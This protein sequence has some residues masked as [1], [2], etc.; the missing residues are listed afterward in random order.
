MRLHRVVV[1][2][3]GTCVVGRAVNVLHFDATEQDAPPVAAIRD[4]YQAMSAQL[5]SGVTVRV[6]GSGETIEDSTGDLTGVWNDAAPAVVVGGV[7]P[8]A[9]A[10]VGA[11]VTWNT[12]GIVTGTAGPRRL[13]G[14]TFLVPLANACFDSD[15]T[16]TGPALASINAFGAGMIAAGGFGVWHRPSSAAATDGTSSSVLSYSLRD[17]V[18]V[19]TSRRD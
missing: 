14:R 13:R 17:K 19:L 18:A 7:V 9:A 4:A 2:W 11:C 15:G 3:A 10:G 8:Q 5:P 6:P 1:E 16:L 12:G